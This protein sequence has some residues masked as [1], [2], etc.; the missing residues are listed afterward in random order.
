MQIDFELKYPL[1]L[2]RF[3]GEERVVLV[4]MAHTPVAHFVNHSHAYEI[5]RLVN[6]AY[7]LV[8]DLSQKPYEHVADTPDHPRR[9]EIGTGLPDPAGTDSVGN[10]DRIEKAV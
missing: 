9:S 7:K 6:C 2:R 3:K 5:V 4:D 10:S 1:H 8:S